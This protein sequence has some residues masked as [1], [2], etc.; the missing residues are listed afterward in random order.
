M[1]LNPEHYRRR[2]IRLKGYDYLQSGAYFV[3]I[4]AHNRECLFGD[5]TGGEMRCNEYGEI[6]RQEWFKTAEI[7]P[8]VRLD[9]TEFVVMPNH[10]HGIIWI[11]DDDVGARRRRV[12]TIE[13]FGKPV[14]D[15]IP[16]IIRAFKSIVT[17]RI[18]QIRDTP[19]ALA[20]QSN[21]YEHIIRNEESVNRIRQY[22][23]DNPRHWAF[24]RENPDVRESNFETH[25]E[26]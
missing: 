6:V 4:C 16:T 24:D 13:Q 8:Y 1:K 10:V 2:S 20:W 7:R 17:R 18:N 15:S 26:I 9:E 12:P 3:T 14:C 19:G 23:A 21:Y 11:T 5:V 22:I 25:G